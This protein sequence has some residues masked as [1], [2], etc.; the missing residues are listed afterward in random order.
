MCFIIEIRKCSDR[1]VLFS[2]FFP[3]KIRYLM[4]VGRNNTEILFSKMCICRVF[5]ISVQILCV[6]II[7]DFINNT[8][9]KNK[10]DIFS[11]NKSFYCFQ[12]LLQLVC[13]Q[14]TMF[15]C[16]NIVVV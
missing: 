1:R 6:L 10:T 4:R 2:D 5:L 3:A 11:N 7:T 8:Q 14:N 13:I 9:M 15:V 12:M 16:L